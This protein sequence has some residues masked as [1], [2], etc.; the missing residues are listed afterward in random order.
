MDTS[1][2]TDTLGLIAQ[3]RKLRDPHHAITR[4][5]D[6]LV[7]NTYA[8]G[9]S[10]GYSDA[11]NEVLALLRRAPAPPKAEGNSPTGADV[12]SNAAKEW[13]ARCPRDPKGIPYVS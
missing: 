9:Y 2:H 5:W 4:D 13:F 12:W 8:A 3:L 6:D 11:I 1:T 10:C 7:P